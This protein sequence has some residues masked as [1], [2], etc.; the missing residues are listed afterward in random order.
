MKFR[1]LEACSRGFFFLILRLFLRPLPQRDGPEEGFLQR[2]RRILV[3]RVD[4]I[5]DL[6]ISTPFLNALRRRF[7]GAEIVCLASSLNV[8][9]LENSPDV[10][11]MWVFSW[12][13]AGGIFLRLLR[14]R[15]DLT[16]DLNPSYSLT[17]GLLTRL[18]RSPLRVSY[19]CRQD[20]F[21]YHLTLDPG[22]ETEHVFQKLE[23]LARVFGMAPLS[24]RYRVYPSPQDR[25][26]ALEVLRGLGWL[27][28]E[29][30]VGI[31]SGNVRKFNN[32][33]PEWK[34]AATA[35]RLMREL[36]VSIYW[37]QG[38]GEGELLERIFGHLP[39]PDSCRVI[40]VLP[41]LTAAA[42]LERMRL[43]IC[44]STSLL[45]VAAAM[46]TSTL[47]LSSRYNYCWRPLGPEHGIVL[48]TTWS[49]CR[50]IGV[51]EVFTV[52]K[53]LLQSRK[54]PLLNPGSRVE[55]CISSP[56]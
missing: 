53:R 48:D 10:D 8:G 7:P 26:K 32:R 24:T 25:E 4:R 47:C 5:G 2:V 35:E 52:A 51:G 16:L 21:F 50:A 56:L 27:P 18:S 14:R 13:K 3:L 41:I 34:F 40:P 19:A 12:R 38:P 54:A 20:R 44:N 49:S 43:L 55:R 29:Q 28:E 15:F 6:V 11:Q 17:S 31:H 22:P 39:N 37:F 30:A 36:G 23:R 1:R 46:G 42:A 45:H 33:W 9:A